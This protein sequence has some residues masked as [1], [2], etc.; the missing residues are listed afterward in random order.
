MTAASVFFFSLSHAAK[1]EAGAAK[2]HQ[3]GDTE[4]P[5]TNYPPNQHGIG[6]ITDEHA[7]FFFFTTTRLFDKVSNQSGLSLQSDGSEA[8]GEDQ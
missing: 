7:D 8:D 2:N 1:G 5:V 3:S 4:A 6:K